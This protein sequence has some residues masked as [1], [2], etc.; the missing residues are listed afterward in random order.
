MITDNLNT[1]VGIIPHYSYNADREMKIDVLEIIEKDDGS[2]EVALDIDR[3][4]MDILIREGFASIV[5]KGLK[6]CLK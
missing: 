3:K 5:N 1:T 6:Q 4:G 2:A